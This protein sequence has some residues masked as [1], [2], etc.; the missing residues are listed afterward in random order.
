MA[1]H[2]ERP[3]TN[4]G[5]PTV[6]VLRDVVQRLRRLEGGHVLLL[7]QD[8]HP[9]AVQKLEEKTDKSATTQGIR[10]EEHTDKLATKASAEDVAEL[11]AALAAMQVAIAAKADASELQALEVSHTDTRASLRTILTVALGSAGAGG[12]ITWAALQLGGG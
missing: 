1:S 10:L 2:Y 4:P 7:G 12:G 11:R 5:E 8:G 9:G 3:P 6:E